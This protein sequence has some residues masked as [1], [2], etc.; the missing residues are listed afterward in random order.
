MKRF[1]FL[2]LIV[3]SALAL[4]GCLSDS[5]I[6]A[7]IPTG[8]SPAPAD[9]GSDVVAPPSKPEAAQSEA[10]GPVLATAEPAVPVG[11][12][13]DETLVDEQG[14]VAVSVK[15]L[16][17][18]EDGST[19]DFEVAMNTHSV[20]LSMDLAALATLASDTGEQVVA[21][22]WEAPLGGHH[23]SGVLSFPATSAGG[24]LLEGAT[25]ITLTLVDVDAPAR[26]FTWRVK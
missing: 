1:V 14:A 2:F 21:T 9:L 17:I 13:P 16:V 20:D 15:P 26:T 7:A 19:L 12:A 24:R 4:A 6:A 22:V 25:T 11:A 8:N 10:E 18:G 5:S 3:V 23:V